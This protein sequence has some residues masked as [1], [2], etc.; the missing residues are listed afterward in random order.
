MPC[1][2]PRHGLMM[3]NTN[4]WIDAWW[5][6]YIIASIDCPQIFKK[7][8][9]CRACHTYTHV[10]TTHGMPPTSS[11]TVSY[12]ILSAAIMIETNQPVGVL[13]TDPMKQRM[14]N[15]AHT[16]Y[17]TP[18][19]DVMHHLPILTWDLWLLIRPCL[20][21]S[22]RAADTPDWITIKHAWIHQQIHE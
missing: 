9:N 12:I 16:S 20:T 21:L 8:N 7:K 5:D 18:M 4:F 19:N 11:S 2:P 14:S 13:F 15:K 17:E 6:L 3:E 1:M 10:P 22:W